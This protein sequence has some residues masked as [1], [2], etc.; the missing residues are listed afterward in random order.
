MKN[1]F[2]LVEIM[3]AIFVMITGIVGVYSLLSTVVNLKSINVGRFMASQLASEGMELVHNLRDQNWLQGI[4]WDTGL[5]NCSIPAQP[6][7]IDYNDFGLIIA[8]RFLKIQDNGFYNY[9]VGADTVYKRKITIT[10]QGDA[11]NVKVKVLW[12]GRRPFSGFGENSFELEENF[13][14][15]K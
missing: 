9:E 11:L 2:T 15:W 12:Q 8:D 1:G 6:C 3:A 13:Y 5:T 7:E 4:A 14:D 10:Q